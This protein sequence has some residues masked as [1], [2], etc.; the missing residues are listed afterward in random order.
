ME[1][2]VQTERFLLREIVPED[3]A[4]L[5]KLDSDVEV[6]RYLG[7]K[8]V[9]T[10]EEVREVIK[11]IRKQYDE[12]GIGRWAIID[13]TTGEFVGWSGLK[14]VRERINNRQLL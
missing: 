1:V 8:P 12:N 13:K 2:F 4:A 6:H 7:S 10:I 11:F 5:Y 3:E 9:K 14:L